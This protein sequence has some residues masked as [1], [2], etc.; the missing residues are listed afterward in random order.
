MS[1][2]SARVNSNRSKA[3]AFLNRAVDLR[4]ANI[5]FIA[6]TTTLTLIAL[7]IGGRGATHCHRPCRWPFTH[8]RNGRTVD[9]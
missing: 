7:I 9:Q 8:V 3:F 2:Q 6:P 4:L 5:P 1:K